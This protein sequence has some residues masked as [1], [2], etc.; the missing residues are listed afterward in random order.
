MNIL[1]NK[2]S[3]N[4]ILFSQETHSTTSDE[5]KWKNE[6]SRPVFYSHGT[7]N[8]CG[9][10][11]TFFGKNKICFNS[12]INDKHGRILILDVTIDGSENTLVNFYNANT[13]NEQL[14]VLNDHL[15]GDLFFDRNLEVMGSKPILKEKSV[16]RM[17]E[18]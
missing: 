4:G 17:F 10:F 2:I 6:F 3:K 18:L 12:Q 9:V 16:A 7:S 15:A 1:K 8:T 5:G 14:K 11:I 13:E